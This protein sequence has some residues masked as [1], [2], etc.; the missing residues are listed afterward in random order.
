MTSFKW[1]RSGNHGPELHSVFIRHRLKLNSR[2]TSNRLKMTS[3]KFRVV[4]C[5]IRLFPTLISK[6][7]WLGYELPLKMQSLEFTFIWISGYSDVGDCMMVTDLNVGDRITLLATFF[8]MLV[9]LVY[10]M[11]SVNRSPTSQSCHQHRCSRIIS[12][13]SQQRFKNSGLKG[14]ICIFY[15][16]PEQNQ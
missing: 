5:R 13:A 8:I 12:T 7:K 9:F 15:F 14:V 6:I 16:C 1:W 4:I 2:S 3:F 10:Y 11:V